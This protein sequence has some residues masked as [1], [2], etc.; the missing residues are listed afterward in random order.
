MNSITSIVEDRTGNVWVST[1]NYLYR[2]DG[3]SWTSFDI[4]DTF[5]VTRTNI[6]VNSVII[7]N[8]NTVWA[9]TTSGILHFDGTNWKI[10]TTADGIADN[11]I[12]GFIQDRSGNIWAY[13][14]YSGLNLFDGS[15]WQSSFKD[16]RVVAITQDNNGNLWLATDHGVIKY[17]GNTFQSYTTADG[18]LDDSIHTIAIDRNNDVWCG[19]DYGVNYFNGKIWLAMTPIQGLA[20]NQILHIVTATSGDIWFSAF[21]GVS[22]YHPVA[23]SQSTIHIELNG[24]V[25]VNTDQLTSIAVT[26]AP[27]CTLAP[28][29]SQQYLAMGTYFDAMRQNITARVT[30]ASSN[31]AVAAISGDGLAI[32]RAA[33]STVITATLSGITG[34][35]VTLVVVA[36]ASTTTTP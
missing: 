18:L 9:A 11:Y 24:P 32:G 8:Q 16:D 21:G 27:V 14:F 19:T 7:D 31:T 6:Q 15:Y 4:R 35:V 29:V 5:G 34:P 3:K 23:E 2:F 12:A 1:T 36:P 13:G 17:D 20:G 30:W 28:G 22:R 33:G 26:P 10:Y 25:P